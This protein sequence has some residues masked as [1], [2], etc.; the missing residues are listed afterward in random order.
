MEQVADDPVMMDDPFV[1]WGKLDWKFNRKPLARAYMFNRLR[2]KD[3]YEKYRR[4]TWYNDLEAPLDLPSFQALSPEQ[5]QR[6]RDRAR[7][8]H[9]Q[10]MALKR[11]VDRGWEI[12]T[13]T[14]V[15]AVADEAM[16][17]EMGII[18]PA[19]QHLKTATGLDP[20]FAVAW[21]DLAY[22]AGI[23]GDIQLQQES[24]VA[25][26]NALDTHSVS[27]EEP[28][29]RA[30][31]HL[32]MLLDLAWTHRDLGSYQAGLDE[33]QKAIKQMAA[34][35]LRTLD[36][37]RE[38]MLLQA[39]LM[40]DMGQIHD[41]R[42]LARKLPEWSL[43][44]INSTGTKP[45]LSKKNHQHFDSPFAKNWVWMLTYKQEESREQ[46]LSRMSKRDFMTEFP[47]HINYRYWRDQGEVLEHFG[48]RGESQ[49]AYGFSILY[50]PY[51]PFFPLQ[52]ARGISRIL[53]QKGTGMAYYLGHKHFYVGGSLYSY[54][55]NRIVAMEMA[56][57]EATL[58]R[59]AR[60]A[61]EALTRCERRGLHPTS[62]R[63]LRGRAWYRLGDQERALADLTRA[64]QELKAADSRSP[65]VVQLLAIIK[66]DQ[67][68]Y[69]DC[70][71]WLL[72]YVQLLPLDGFGWRLSG[73]ALGQMGRF[74]EAINVLERATRLEP[75]SVAGWYNLAIMHLQK[76]QYDL[77][78]DHLATAANLEPD[79]TQV[80][81]LRTLIR[82]DPEQPVK[83]TMTPV[84]LH[85][86]VVEDLWFIPGE[87]S[88]V[89]EI[90][91]DL[92]P[93]EA[94]ELV[95]ERQAR[96]EVEGDREARLA[97]AQALIVAEEFAAVQGLLAPLWP[98][99]LSRPE[100]VQLLR[101]DRKLGTVTR[102]L[103][104]AATLGQGT[105]P[106]PDSQFWTLVAAIC[107]E[108][109]EPEAGRRALA[110]ARDLD[111]GNT[112][113]EGMADR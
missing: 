47:P 76:G 7:D 36:E 75:E 97:L 98:G 28:E 25:G 77:A 91:T 63:A 108:N 21:Y 110:V 58:E 103:A 113:L 72:E 50:R 20:G 22:F 96:Y 64:H 39:L 14:Q 32:R 107:L 24:L 52:G 49:L 12:W 33:V 41:A 105:E 23:V 56:E 35:D 4:Q 88:A 29:S 70:L 53:D 92:T 40:A 51:F 84:A 112:E 31:L 87:E 85:T 38:A 9:D 18:T 48:E 71:D 37:A 6:R 79:N 78:R 10:A 2:V 34:D 57:D 13:Q 1:D 45:A 74:D 5:Q 67:A 54:A 55:A 109:G 68:A 100:A 16:T 30:R 93:E 83:M 82:T 43:P 59:Q 69:Q 44:Q 89:Q 104:M 19:L 65:K 27:V 95:L 99:E 42:Q 86:K 46:A 8:H 15:Y 62:C 80:A 73:L 3:P 81:N 17:H 90:L 101:S 60:M 11:I 111:P 106:Y 66:Y 61:V 26:L 102:A 94:R